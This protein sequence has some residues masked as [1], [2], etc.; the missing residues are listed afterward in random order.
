MNA[1]LTLVVTGVTKSETYRTCKKKISHNIKTFKI[2]WAN[3]S[4]GV[5]TIMKSELDLSQ[6]EVGLKFDH[7]KTFSDQ[8]KTFIK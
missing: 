1:R 5:T 8:K 3:N 4:N 6:N 7:V 2:V